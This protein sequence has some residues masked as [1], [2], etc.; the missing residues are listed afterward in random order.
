MGEIK[1]D[2]FSYTYVNSTSL[3][4]NEFIIFVSYNDYKQ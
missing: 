2:L 1:N 4:V 3:N